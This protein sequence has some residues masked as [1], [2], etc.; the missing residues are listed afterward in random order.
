MASASGTCCYKR[1]RK[2]ELNFIRCFLSHLTIWQIIIIMVMI[3]IV[4]IIILIISFPV[5]NESLHSLK[6]KLY[7]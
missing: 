7:L 1:S 6:I 4:I 5:N 3:I 2:I